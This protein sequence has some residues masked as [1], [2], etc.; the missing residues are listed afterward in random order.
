MACFASTRFTGINRTYLV[1]PLSCPRLALCALVHTYLNLGSLCLLL[2][3]VM[4]LCSLALGCW[5]TVGDKI[6]GRYMKG[7]T[8]MKL[9]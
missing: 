5:S 4:P 3:L 9:F 1:L 7:Q 2:Y 6:R 8:R